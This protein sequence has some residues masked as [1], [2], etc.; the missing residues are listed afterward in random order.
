MKKFSISFIAFAAT[1]VLSGCSPS[2]DYKLTDS[3]LKDSLKTFNQ[4]CVAKPSAP[5][6]ENKEA[7]EFDFL[8]GEVFYGKDNSEPYGEYSP[9]FKPL[10]SYDQIDGDYYDSVICSN[11]PKDLAQTFKFPDMSHAKL[12]IELVGESF[13]YIPD[14]MKVRELYLNAE[15]K[16]EASALVK[17]LV[18]VDTEKPLF[19]PAQLVIEE[20]AGFE[21]F[22]DP[23]GI[24]VESN[25]FGVY[26]NGSMIRAFKSY[27][28]LSEYS[29][30][31]VVV[32]EE[33]RIPRTKY[34]MSGS[35]PFC[36]NYGDA[37]NIFYA[38]DP[39]GER[40]DWTPIS[41]ALVCS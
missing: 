37:T 17:K 23:L 32:R 31:H 25:T 18:F 29:N 22:P 2:V 15:N 33:D 3:Q 26:F 27:G 8:V 38:E 34:R 28:D 19:S 13:S 7:Q 21:S 24:E 35:S 9:T 11:I 10:A 20:P 1:M 5:Y 6:F 39:W 12:S 16:L 4:Y 30:L 41:K 14:S 36:E 40:S